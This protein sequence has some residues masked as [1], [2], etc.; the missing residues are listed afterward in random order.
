[1]NK[2]TQEYGRIHASIV[3]SVLA[4]WQIASNMNELIQERSRIHASIAERALAI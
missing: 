2:L 3:E 1:M 4:N